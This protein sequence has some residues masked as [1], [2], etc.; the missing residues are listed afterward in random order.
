MSGIQAYGDYIPWI[1]PWQ[2][3]EPPMVIPSITHTSGYIQMD[4][5]ANKS[6]IEALRKEIAELRALVAALVKP[7]GTLVIDGV[8]YM[9]TNSEAKK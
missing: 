1:N 6:D 3:C 8:E 2:P 4:P 9:R 5:L 7:A